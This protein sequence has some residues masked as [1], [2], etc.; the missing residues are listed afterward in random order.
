[1]GIDDRLSRLLAQSEGVPRA[2]GDAGTD[3]DADDTSSEATDET[4]VDDNDGFRRAAV[5]RR[6]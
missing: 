1:M 2:A 4:T 5:D 6:R 3:G